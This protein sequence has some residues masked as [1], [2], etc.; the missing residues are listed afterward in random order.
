MS[1]TTSM[2]K[3]ALV[4]AAKSTTA[5]ATVEAA[6]EQLKNILE[7]AGVD[8]DVLD[9]PVVTMF[10]QV[11]AP[12]L[13]HQLAE[14]FEDQI[15]GLPL[16]KPG[17][18]KAIAAGAM[19]CERVVLTK[20]GIE[21]MK[22]VMP[23]VMENLKG[24]VGGFA[25]LGA[26]EDDDDQILALAREIEAAKAVPEEEVVVEKPKKKRSTKKKSTKKTAKK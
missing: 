25:T 17:S 19:A 10:L 22:V 2:V 13:V 20:H 6:V 5:M 18:A 21:A 14:A 7:R 23:I 24:M 12:V 9:L 8:R 1:S 16:M 3:E 4:G 15:D 26:A 11:G